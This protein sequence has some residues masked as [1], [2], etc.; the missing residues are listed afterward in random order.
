MDHE[1]ITRH[2]LGEQREVQVLPS[3]PRRRLSRDTGS[4]FITA[5]ALASGPLEFRSH[6]HFES[7]L[8]M[9]QLG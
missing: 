7:W 6:F 3:A 5:L 4:N 9:A 1:Y 8:G 2:A